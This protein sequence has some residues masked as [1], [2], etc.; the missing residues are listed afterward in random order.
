MSENTADLAQDVDA[1]RPILVATDFS[2]DS[3]AALLWAGRYAQLSG[4]PLLVLHVIHDP[5]EAAGFYLRDESDAEKTMSEVADEMMVA[6]L[7]GAREKY[8]EL[9]TIGN[10][11][12]EL[13]AGLPPTRIV[14]V[15]D[16]EDAELI[17]I[18][19]RGRSRLSGILIGSVADRVVQLASRPVVIVKDQSDG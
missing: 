19:S 7:D 1:V 15:A 14:E 11:R 2:A 4:A 13:V 8:P 3:A 16:R 9:K 10:A 6:F 18:G 12:P 17:V 5:A